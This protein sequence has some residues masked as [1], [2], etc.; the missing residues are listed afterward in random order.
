MP[1]PNPNFIIVLNIVITTLL[2][3]TQPIHHNTKISLFSLLV[4]NPVRLET[5]NTTQ[6]FIRSHFSGLVTFSYTSGLCLQL[7]TLLAF[8]PAATFCLDY[9]KAFTVLTPICP[10]AKSR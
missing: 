4:P 8:A 10:V 6:D 1:M 7:S 3:S 9:E 2:G 5:N